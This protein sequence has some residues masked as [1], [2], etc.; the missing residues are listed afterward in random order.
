M[1]Q[2]HSDSDRHLAVQREV[3]R[4][5][6]AGVQGFALTSFGMIRFTDEHL[7]T[8]TAEPDPFRH[9]R[10]SHQLAT[11][12][13]LRLARVAR[14]GVTAGQLQDRRARSVEVEWAHPAQR[15]SRPWT[16]PHTRA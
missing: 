10:V 6:L 5:A 1:T 4:V 11:A 16:K 14:Y 3:A 2:E 12:A 15:S 13:K 7:I 8:A 9:R